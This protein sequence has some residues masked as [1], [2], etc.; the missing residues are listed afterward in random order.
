MS[1][2]VIHEST[3]ASGRR[4]RT[5]LSLDAGDA[6]AAGASGELAIIVGDESFPLPEGAL[7]AVMKRYGKPLAVAVANLAVQERLD[8]GAGRSLVRFRFLARY[9][10][11]A[12]DYLALLGDGEDDPLCELATSVA[13]VLDHLARRLAEA[14]REPADE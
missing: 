4:V 13:A 12:H 2:M 11:I 1:E 14:G 8:L 10:V 7:E 6:D 3:D 9:D 5:R